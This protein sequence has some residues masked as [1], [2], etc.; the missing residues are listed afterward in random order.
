MTIHEIHAQVPELREGFEDL[1]S[2]A[3]FC[4][5]LADDEV[6]V[7]ARR[8]RD[9]ARALLVATTRSLADRTT[10]PATVTVIG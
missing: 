1:V 2:F 10:T 9:S 4:C 3:D 5:F 7:E 6:L 8:L